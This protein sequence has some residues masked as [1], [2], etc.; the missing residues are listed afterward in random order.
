[1]KSKLLKYFIVYGIN[2][3]PLSALYTACIKY[4]A[5]K[6]GLAIYYFVDLP[7]TFYYSLLFNRNH[8]PV[9]SKGSKNQRE[10]VNILDLERNLEQIIFFTVEYATQVIQLSHSRI[11]THQLINGEIAIY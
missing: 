6:I 9:I 10:K 3:S 8:Q 1:M 5:E 7:S 2:D 4:I 11:I